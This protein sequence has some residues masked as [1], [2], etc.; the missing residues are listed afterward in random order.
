MSL[1]LSIVIREHILRY[2]HIAKG[3]ENE[4]PF[5]VIIGLDHQG[6]GHSEG[7]RLFVKEFNDY[8]EDVTYLCNL[9][10]K[11]FMNFKN[12]FLLA[13]SM[14]GLIGI[15]VLELHPEIEFKGSI[16]SAPSLTISNPKIMQNLA[17]FGCNYF[18]KYPGPVLNSE[19]LCHDFNVINLFVNDPLVTSRTGATLNLASEVLKSI[20]SIDPSKISV[21]YLLIRGD[22]DQ[23]CLREGIIN[24][25]E[26]TINCKY[27]T[28]IELPNLFHEI[29]NEED[30]KVALP[31]VINFL[32]NMILET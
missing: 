26:K 3:I 1:K 21:P 4:I 2:T 22:A 11:K 30:G 25:H 17:R 12:I 27:K 9:M 6:H 13:H 14:G 15:K 10:K 29:F 7:D 24:W 23:I 8:V 18:P 19:L 20:D 32:R 28:L 16:I 5:T 31:Y